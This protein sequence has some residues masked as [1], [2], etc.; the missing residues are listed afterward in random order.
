MSVE[1][2]VTMSGSEIDGKWWFSKFY[3]WC[4]LESYRSLDQCKLISVQFWN[5]DF[6]MSKKKWKKRQ[7][8]GRTSSHHDVRKLS[9]NEDFRD[10]NFDVGFVITDVIHAAWFQPSL[11]F[12][13]AGTRLT[14]HRPLQIDV[15]WSRIEFSIGANWSALNFEISIFKCQNRKQ[16]VEKNVEIV[17]ERWITMGGSE[18]GEKMMILRHQ[19]WRS[20]ESYRALD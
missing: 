20:L 15:R 4:S 16:N 17:V 10:I 7:N 1:R 6:Q 9:K 19:F 3:F 12:S 2:W 11:R 13:R 8:F 14:V 18:I 5:F